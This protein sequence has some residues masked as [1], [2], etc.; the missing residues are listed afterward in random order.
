MRGGQ[1][2]SLGIFTECL[3]SDKPVTVAHGEGN[4]VRWPHVTVLGRLTVFPVSWDGP[5]LTPCRTGASASMHR[6][7]T[8]L[9]DTA[10]EAEAAGAHVGRTDGMRAA[11]AVEHQG[12]PYP[13]D[14]MPVAVVDI[15]ETTREAGRPRARGAREVW[16]PGARGPLDYAPTGVH[17]VGLL[18][19]ASHAPNNPTS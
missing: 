7:V 15:A 11:A 19:C 9:F 14:G 13:R 2:S 18:S 3:L 12:V 8:V 17:R 16:A 6:G 4:E 5:T 1:A 10:A